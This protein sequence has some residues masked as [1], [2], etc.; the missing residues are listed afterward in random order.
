[1]SDLSS[2]KYVSFTTYTKSGEEK[3]TPVW[4]VDLGDG[5]MGFNTPPD[6]WKVKRLANDPRVKLQPSDMK[7][8]PKPGST[9]HAG[10]AEVVRG[11]GSDRVHGAV[12]SKYG[13]QVLMIDTVMKLKSLVGKAPSERVGIVVT[14]D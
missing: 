5:T 14:L 7:G 12:K 13:F 3:S 4:I 8:V 10:T 2:E 9:I 6:S 1:M 11:A